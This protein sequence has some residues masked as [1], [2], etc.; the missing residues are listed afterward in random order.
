LAKEPPE[1]FLYLHGGF[2]VFG[3]A[4]SSANDKLREKAEILK[5]LVHS[6][7]NSSFKPNKPT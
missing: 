6:K 2:C 5:T 1:E 4:N 3:A 7:K